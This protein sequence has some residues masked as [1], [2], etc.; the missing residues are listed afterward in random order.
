MIFNK[1][2]ALAMMLTVASIGRSVV[3]G[4]DTDLTSTRTARKLQK[5]NSGGGGGGT[6]YAPTKLDAK[7]EIMM[8]WAYRMA[9]SFDK[10]VSTNANVEGNSPYIPE[11]VQRSDVGQHRGLST[12][13]GCWFWDFHCLECSLCE[14]DVPV[15]K[16]TY[17]SDLCLVS[18]VESVL[19][20]GGGIEDPVASIVAWSCPLICKEVFPVDCCCDTYQPALCD[21]H[22]TTPYG[23]CHAAEGIC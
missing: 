22:P 19:L 18:C 20:L 15:L 23:I 2:T 21:R 7:Q 11:Y 4:A 14:I 3:E 1:N 5:G 9:L 6:W 13:G 12:G 16:K 10:P 8:D 17:T